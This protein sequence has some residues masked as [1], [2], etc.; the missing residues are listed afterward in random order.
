MF[1][2]LNFY[3]FTSFSHSG[4]ELKEHYSCLKALTSIHSCHQHYSFYR[5]SSH[6]GSVVM[7]PTSIHEDKGSIPGPAQGVKDLSYCE[8]YKQ[9]RS[10]MWLRFGTAVAV[11]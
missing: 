9:C 3:F 7:N 10:Q 5:R 2:C 11:A 8:L 4:S 1:V 6:C